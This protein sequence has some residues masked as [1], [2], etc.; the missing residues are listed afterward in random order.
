MNRE[1]IKILK[2]IK[3]SRHGNLPERINSLQL[4]SKEVKAGD[5][6]FALRGEQTDGHKF[7]PEAVRNNAAAVVAEKLTENLAVPQIIVSD[8]RAALAQVAANFY[9]H[10]SR[11]LKIIGVTG[12]NG[13]TT[14]VYLLNQIFKS[15][16]KSRGTIGTLGYSINDHYQLLNLTTPDSIQLQQILSEMVVA[17]V[18]YVAMEVS[19]HALS[20]NRV[21]TIDF[22][23]GIFTNISQ[24]H[25]DFY[26]DMTHYIAA[27]TRLFKAVSDKGF[28]LSN[29]DDPHAPDFNQTGS[30]PL[31]TYGMKKTADF[32]W[33]PG[34]EY[35]TSISGT[36]IYKNRRIPVTSKLSGY[37]NLSN[38]LA[39]AGTA[40][41]CGLSAEQIS[42][43]LSKVQYIPGRVQEITRPGAPRVFVD[44]AHTPDAIVNVLTALR[45]L[46]PPEGKL[47]T[48]FGCG[49]NR[50]R[51]K[52]P[53]MAAA[54]ATHSD[55]VIITTD[56]PRHEEPED[57]ICDALAGFP[58]D[59]SYKKIVNRKA[60]IE[61]AIRNAASND[62]IAILGKGHENYQEIKGVKYPFSDVEIVKEYINDNR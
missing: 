48:L 19:A 38:I 53:Q 5:L 37:F 49:G 12:T 41:C 55:F 27:K 33:S 46:V 58:P 32:S 17:K 57:I 16:Q 21:D 14:T 25:L 1:T 2:G 10:P 11:H 39:A 62:I 43:A 23:G 47:I 45:N 29:A 40:I 52:R 31:F 18:E 24:D 56:N 59:C 7:I 35:R 20:L 8:S 50:D 34:V 15:A 3:C 60:A 9:G 22:L 26:G 6:F 13:K 51:S 61:S 54:A 44:Y 42:D 4:N 36:I 28:R 30:A